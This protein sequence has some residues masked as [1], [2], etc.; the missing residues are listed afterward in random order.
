MAFLILAYLGGILTIISPCILPVLPFV[1]SRA[2]QPF[3]R[4]GL[5]LLVG[6]A[7]TFAAL[8]A[9][10]TVAGGWMVRA[11]QY[12]RIA[13]L[14]FLAILGLTLIWGGLADRLTHPFVQLGSRLTQPSPTGGQPSISQALLLGI[15]TGLLWAPC[16]GPILGLILTGAAVGGANARTAF[17]LLAYAAG[18][19]TSLAVALFA[20]GSVFRALKGSLGADVWIRRA[21]GI[22]VLAGVAAIALGVDRG[23]LTQLSLSST[24][25]VEQSLVNRLQPKAAAAKNDGPGM[26]MMSSNA[27]GKGAGPEALP[28]LSGAVEWLNSAP[29]SRDQLKGHVVLVDFW[30]YSCI[31]CLRTL[32]YIRAWAERY[33]GDGFTVLGVHT[34]EFAF[35]KDP[36]NVRRAVRELRITYPVPLDNDYSIWKAFNNQFWPSDYLVDSTGRVRYHHFGE[37]KYDETESHIQELLKESNAKL[38]FNGGTEVSGSGPEAPPDNDVQSPETYV[39]YERADSFLS[40][41]GFVK[42]TAHAYTIP[43]HLELNQWGLS[44]N[45][46]DQPQ[47]AT[48]NSA[49]GK[50]VFRFHARDVHLV[51]GPSKAGKPVRY[52][53]KIDGKPPEESHGGDTDSNGNGTV[54][55]HRLYQLIRRKNST[56]D[57]T[58]E[59]QFLDSGVQVFSFTFG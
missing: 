52:R 20:G 44:G 24:S 51:L 57:H 21:L 53:V 23:V 9:V 34:P 28:G 16:A 4:S 48:L 22:A 7:I 18:A 49:P 41:G 32:P 3:R 27:S 29:L 35:E 13:A 59:I 25:G 11:N 14:I 58:F 19:A 39:G 56:D 33:K 17:L 37:G 47:V 42:D 30:T 43:E 8:A 55:D 12:G 6:M 15:A 46:T 2:D 40:P 45:W 1:F 50:I 31:N 38:T 5:P 54:L 36:D 26:M 10:A